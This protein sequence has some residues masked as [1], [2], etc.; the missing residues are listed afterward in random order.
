[1]GL[2]MNDRMID[3]EELLGNDPGM[4]GAA[5]HDDWFI[6][7]TE[8]RP[9]KFYRPLKAIEEMMDQFVGPGRVVKAR[10]QA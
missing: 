5:Q 2:A 1:M 7:N 3:L 4:L 8:P 9:S 6:E 10:G